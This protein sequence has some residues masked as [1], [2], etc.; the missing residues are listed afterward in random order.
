MVEAERAADPE[1]QAVIN[2]LVEAVPCAYIGRPKLFPLIT[3]KAV[4]FSLRYGHT[5]QSSFAYGVYALMLVSMMG[6]IP[7]A[8]AFSELSLRL[9]EKLQNPRLR[10]TLLHLHGDH[11]NFWRRHFATGLPI[12]EQAFVACQE[13]GD[14]VYAGFLSFETVWQLLEKGDPLEPVLQGPK[15]NASFPQESH[16]DPIFQTIRLEQQFVKSLQG[17]TNDPLGLE[18]GDF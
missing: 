18:D 8:F 2:L 10:G 9:N 13:V 14:L 6:D 1:M 12:L 11:V 3:L 15:R 7:S 5:E 16:N 4:N 17:K